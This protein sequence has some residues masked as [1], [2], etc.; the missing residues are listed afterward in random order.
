MRIPLLPQSLFAR[1]LMGLVAA[2][3]TAMLII[4]LL[5]VRDRRDIVLLGSGAWN[6]AGAIAQI[7]TEIAG[8]RGEERDRVLRKYLTVPVILESARAVPENV[9]NAEI[10]Q[11]ANRRQRDIEQMERSFERRV[12]RQLGDEY[13]V[14]VAPRERGVRRVIRLMGDP[15]RTS[16]GGEP[17]RQRGTEPRRVN[18]DGA[19]LFDV[20]VRS[21]CALCAW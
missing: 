2:V 14:S 16:S 13:S 1:L 18:R 5:I 3:G 20:A 17:L 6:A 10:E 21:H 8:L 19:R 12:R 9:R 7:S 4:V 11:A 15:E